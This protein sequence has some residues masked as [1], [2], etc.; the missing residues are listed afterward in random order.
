MAVNYLAWLFLSGLATSAI[1]SVINVEQ[2]PTA[3]R[4]GV[5]CSVSFFCGSL[6][7]HFSLF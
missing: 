7:M 2:K 6:A 4:I 5:L 1:A 3:F